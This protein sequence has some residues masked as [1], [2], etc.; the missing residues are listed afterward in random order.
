MIILFSTLSWG[1]DQQSP[2]MAERY[3]PRRQ[4]ATI[5]YCGLGGAVLGLSTLSFYGR[6][7]DKLT[8][9]A[10]GFG[11]G[12]I[13]GAVYMTYQ[14]ATKPDEFYRAHHQFIES[15]QTQ[16]GY[17]LAQILPSEHQS[18]IGLF[19]ILELLKVY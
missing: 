1:Q 9:I 8:N 6:P 14:A 7:Q 11:A 4:I 2:T 18:P 19:I 10:L 15:H 17:S 3:G 13:I 16:D 5:V 12:I